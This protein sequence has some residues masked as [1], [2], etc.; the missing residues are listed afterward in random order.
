MKIFFLLFL[1]N[2]ILAEFLFSGN[3]QARP[4]LGINV[5]PIDHEMSQWVFTNRFKHAREWTP[6]A[7]SDNWRT[8]RWSSS[9]ETK[10]SIDGYPLWFNQINSYSKNGYMTVLGTS[11]LYPTG[12]YIVTFKGTG[13]ITLLGDA[14]DLKYKSSNKIEFKV[15]KATTNG[16]ILIVTQPN[17]TYID[18]REKKD[19]L[20][21][22]TFSSKYLEAL[23]PFDLL[24]FSAW[25]IRGNSR[26]PL[27]NFDWSGRRPV[28][29]Y[30]QSGI[31]MVS[32][33]YII[34]LGNILDK[35]IWIS[36]PA[37][38]NDAY[39]RNIS[40][41]LKDNFNS[42][43]LIYVEQGSD[44]GFNNNNSTLEMNVVQQFKKIFGNKN[45]RVKYV[46]STW[47]AAYF[48]NT[49]S[50]YNENDLRQFDAFSIGGDIAHSLELNS[51][52]YNLTKS[53]NF[54]IQDIHELIY[55]QIQIEEINLI[56]LIHKVYI[57]L[58][59]PLIGYN[60]GFKVHA[61]G[62][63][64]RFRKLDSASIEQKL[65]D[66][67]IEALR[68]DMV[69]HLYLDFMQRWYKLGGGLMVLNNLVEKVDRCLNGGGKCGYRSLMENLNQDPYTV[70]KYAAIFKWLN[71]SNGNIPFT[72]QDVALQEETKPTCV[73]CKWGTC[74]L[75]HYFL[76]LLILTNIINNK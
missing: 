34:E 9:F 13:N 60:V 8:T 71:G 14:S 64:S 1:V 52:N 35:N 16:I 42:N 17:V 27:V 25:M 74:H 26:D 47:L 45:P 11:G 66:L 49:I 39:I 67:I 56:Y 65:E 12:D 21:T 72:S 10:W 7:S 51:N 59:V 36:I 70:P 29:Y 46:L 6:I 73:D 69:E 24:R 41:Y 63:A 18:L 75:V 54:T 44:K 3:E 32:I 55:Q 19:Q 37:S 28:T 5:G 57:K 76:F 62:F 68:H 61:P 20:L 22:S 58:K 48:D 15:I 31:N 40:E 4:P 23:R 30:T 43:K 53:I 2:Q 33:E 50:K 38:A